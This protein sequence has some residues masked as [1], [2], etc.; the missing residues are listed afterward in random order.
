MRVKYT[1]DLHIEVIYKNEEDGQLKSASELSNDVAALI[2]DEVVLA[3]GCASV[4]VVNA[5]FETL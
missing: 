4:D 3:D 1:M 2:C 5:R